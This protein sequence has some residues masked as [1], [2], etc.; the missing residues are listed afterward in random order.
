MPKSLE[1]MFKDSNALVAR[2]YPKYAKY[3][4]LGVDGLGS[5]PEHWETPRFVEVLS[6][7]KRTGSPHLPLLSVYLHLGVVRFDDVD[8]R[9]TNATSD[10]LSG[11]QVVEQ[12]EFVANNQ[13]AW[14]GSV[15]V[16]RHH[17][18]ISPAY[19]VFK[20]TRNYHPGY[21]NYLM[22][23]EA[24][25]GQFEICSKGIGSIQR[26]LQWSLLKSRRTFLP[27]LS[28]QIQIIDFLDSKTKEIEEAIRQK[29]RT[30]E[31][32]E[33]YKHSL[34]QQA[35]TKGLDPTVPMKDSGVN[36]LGEVPKHWRLIS[37]RN[38]LTEVSEKGFAE[39][40]LLSITRELGIIERDVD[41]QEGN[42]NFIPPDLSGYK[43]IKRGNF[44]MNKMK[45]WQGSY[46]VSDFTGIVSPAYFVYSL[47]NAI[48][49]SFFHWA[50]R[51][52]VYVGEMAKASDGVRIGQWDLSKHGLK[53]IRLAA[54]INELEQKAIVNFLE[55]KTKEIEE[56]KSGIQVQI[57]HLEEYKDSLIESA[58]TGKIKVAEP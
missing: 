35:V 45:A 48:V 44:G 58:V 39:L 40:P 36:W 27:A 38:V 42:H 20:C 23:S 7:T 41:D 13:Q 52:K 24:S 2:S 54:P 21:L 49:P 26:N 34:I 25:R 17:G 10:D 46:G 18:I 55:S 19:L 29:Q 3:R 37:L 50:V 5:V 4:S 53:E 22:R 9:R 28:E 57:K 33:E 51:S 14:R 30:I 15:G 16:S 47:S 12:N 6:L 31:L 8:E 11:Y 32:L 1:N 56:A 43:R